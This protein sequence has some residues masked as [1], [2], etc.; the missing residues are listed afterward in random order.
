MIGDFFTKPL[1]GGLFRRLRALVMNCPID[2]PPEYPPPW[3]GTPVDAGVSWGDADRT[4]P[5]DDAGMISG[6]ATD[7]GPSRS[8]PVTTPERNTD[9][10][11]TMVHGVGARA[12]HAPAHAPP[13][14]TTSISDRTRWQ[15]SYLRSATRLAAAAARSPL[16][17]FIRSSV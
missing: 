8:G 13:R 5:P 14:T 4:R 17:P 16:L 9:K 12:G 3:I 11:Q 7:S 15:G 10:G 6:P 2:I 1:Q